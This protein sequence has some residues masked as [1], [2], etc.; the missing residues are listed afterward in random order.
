MER[1]QS[2]YL[3]N[4]YRIGLVFTAPAFLMVLC[5]AVYPTLYT[6]Y[7]SFFKYNMASGTPRRFLGL[8]NYINL[9]KDT[10]F[11]HAIAVTLAYTFWGVAFTMI[12]GVLLALL[13]N[14]DG[15]VPGILR[16]VSLL[17]MLICSAALSVAWALMYNYSFGVLNAILDGIG[18]QKINF[19]GEVKN[20]L[21]SLI[22]LDIWQFTPFVMILVLAGLKGIAKELYEAAEIDGANKAQS[23]FSITLPSIK[24]V[25]ITTLIMRIIDTFKTFEKPFMMTNGG[26]ALSTDTINLHVYN[27]A[28]IS[29]EL[30]YGSAGALLIT[31]LIALLSVLFMR[32]SGKAQ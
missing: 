10:Q 11:I 13:L 7:L 21:P 18:L 23:F 6:I 27:T 28:F 22:V 19:L 5:F 30:G 3:W 17:P 1:K 2:K 9:I 12:F 29:Y 24:G 15:I 4:K 25:L 14:K 26:P 20:A 16:S 8:A 31:I 32:I